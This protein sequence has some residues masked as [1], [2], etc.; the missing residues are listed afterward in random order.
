MENIITNPQS[1]PKW[2]GTLNEFLWLCAGVNRKILLQC[3]PDWA[4]YAGQGGLILFTALMAMLSGGYAFFTIFGDVALA[5]GFG[6][7]WGL[8]IFNLDRFIV[9]TMYSDGKYTISWGEFFAGLPRII[10]AIF[11]GIVISTPL[12]MKIFEDQ[13]ETQMV[14]NNIEKANIAMEQG[15]TGNQTNIERRNLLESQR[16]DITSRLAAANEE[17]K[18]EGE[19]SALSGKAGHGAIYKDKEANR[20]AIQRELDSWNASYSQELTILTNQI[21]T[22]STNIQGEVEGANKNKGFCARYEAFSDIKKSSKSAHIV[23]IFIMLLFI[24][25]EIC[26][27]LFKMMVAFGPYDDM[28]SAERHRI[29]I[30]SQK[31]M[32]DLNDSVNTQIQIS[33]SNN[34]NKLAAEAAANKELLEKVSTAQVELMETAIQEWKEQELKKIKE[35]ASRYIKASIG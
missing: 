16:N 7:F 24:I 6:V 28:L 34:Q 10:I 12:E 23:S 18:K 33:S 22:N 25:I 15:R 11:I 2:G 20:D 32:S 21:N 8:L 1:S 27:T 4:K 26:P 9:N 35:D 30:E 3:P 13:I 19:G 5:I 29:K 17:L 31:A 14:M